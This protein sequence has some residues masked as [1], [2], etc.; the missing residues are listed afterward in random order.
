[1]CLGLSHPGL[2]WAF[3]FFPAN[4]VRRETLCNLA[5]RYKDILSEGILVVRNRKFKLVQTIREFIGAFNEKVWRKCGPP[6]WV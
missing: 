3:F 1:M 2:P 5:E 6:G 4:A